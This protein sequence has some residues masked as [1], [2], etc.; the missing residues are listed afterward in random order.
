MQKKNDKVGNKTEYK[1]IRK[2]GEKRDKK[3]K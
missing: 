1:K 3:S 2:K